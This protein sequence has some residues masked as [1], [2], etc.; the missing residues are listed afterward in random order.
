MRQ[1]NDLTDAFR[2][3][4]SAYGSNSGLWGLRDKWERVWFKGGSLADPQG[5]L[6]LTYG[7]L[8]ESDNRGAYVVVGMLNTQSTNPNRIDNSA[9]LSAMSRIVDL[10]SAVDTSENLREYHRFPSIEKRTESILSID[11]MIKQLHGGSMMDRG[12]RRE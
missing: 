1:Y 5:L 9:F 12:S 7:W 3:V 11:E 6:V 2:L 8:L 4:Y 10:V